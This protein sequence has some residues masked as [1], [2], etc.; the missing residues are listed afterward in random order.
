LKWPL[1]DIHGFILGYQ[2]S[3]STDK[4]TPRPWSEVTVRF[5]E[6][7]NPKRN[8]ELRRK[9]RGIAESE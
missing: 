1:P 2:T 9:Q 6:I 4:P 5:L 8:K 3:Y 7:R